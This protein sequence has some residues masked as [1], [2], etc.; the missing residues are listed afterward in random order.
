M[1][2][3]SRKTA[4]F[5]ASLMALALL[6]ACGQKGGL[7]RPEAVTA[8]GRPHPT[9]VVAGKAVAIAPARFETAAVITH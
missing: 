2:N 9:S 6:A 7:V 8:G 5:A 4:R 1:A 3:H